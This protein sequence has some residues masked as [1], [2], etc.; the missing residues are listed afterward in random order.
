MVYVLVAEKKYTVVLATEGFNMDW[1]TY[2]VVFIGCFVITSGLHIL[3]MNKMEE[4]VDEHFEY[5]SKGRKDF[6]SLA[7]LNGITFLIL[8]VL[9]LGLT[10]FI[11]LRMQI[12]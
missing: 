5:G 11:M 10:A 9:T 2:I 3:M 7:T 1:F 12:M 8:F 4:Y 6:E